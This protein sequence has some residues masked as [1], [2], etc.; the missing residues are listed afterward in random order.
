[1]CVCVCAC[2]S[3]YIEK[4]ENCEI[5]EQGRYLRFVVARTEWVQFL[6]GVGDSSMP[7]AYLVNNEE[8]NYYVSL[9][10]YRIGKENCIGHRGNRRSTS[11]D[12]TVSSLGIASSQS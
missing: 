10:D 3:M 2:M 1:M 6:V 12:F 4:E 5:W 8:R 9:S 11:C 7:S